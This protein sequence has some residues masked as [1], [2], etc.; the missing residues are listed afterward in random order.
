MDTS[1]AQHCKPGVAC[2]TRSES[3]PSRHP[4]VYNRHQEQ[5]ECVY[6]HF[7]T[8]ETPSQQQILTTIWLFL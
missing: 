1:L 2:E 6:L 4:W 5:K 7:W 3:P 8:P